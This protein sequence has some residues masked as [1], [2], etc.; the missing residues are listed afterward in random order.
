MEFLLGVVVGALTTWLYRSERAREEVQRRLST[1]PA[2]VQQA[3]QSAAAAAAGGAQKL[4]GA[5]DAAPLPPQ[6]KDVASRATSGLRNTAER[7]GQRP[8]GGGGEAEDTQTL[9]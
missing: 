4:S 2:S 5:V 7:L 6:V 9:P 3:R 1:A 8:E